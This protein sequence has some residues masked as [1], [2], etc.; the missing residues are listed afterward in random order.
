M[1]RS[2]VFLPLFGGIFLSACVTINVYFPAAAAEKA[3]DQIIEQVWGIEQKKPEP[4]PPERPEKESSLPPLW[5]EKVVNFLVSPSYAVAANIDIS[6]STIQMLKD[7]MTQRH[8]ELKPYY[9][10]GAIGLTYGGLIVLRD[11]NFIPLKLRNTVNRS[12]ADENQDRLALY[13]EIAVTNGYPEW[14]ADIRATFSVRWIER[15]QIGWWYQNA[16][17]EWL[18]KKP[19]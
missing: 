6:S 17:G 11:R 1:S 7:R 16:K 10:N 19:Q 2:H 4:T 13:K 8:Q 9:D 14:E 15:A 18:Q 12:I 5:S 3:A